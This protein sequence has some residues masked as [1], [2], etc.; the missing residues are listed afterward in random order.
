M[1]HVIL[2]N[3]SSYCVND[4]HLEPPLGLLYIASVLM[5]QSIPVQVYDMTGCKTKEDIIKKIEQIPFGDIY[6]FT[7]YCTNYLYVK[8]CIKHIRT[9]Y[10][11]AF[12]ILGGPNPSALPKF[13]LT[14]SQCDC[15]IT[16]EG[17]D[18]FLNIV[19]NFSHP[20]Y[21]SK[22]IQ[23]VGRQ[24]I[25]SYPFPARDLVNL[26]SY[27]RRSEDKR[28]I[29]LIGSRG[30]KYN[31]THCNSVVMGGGGKI[32]YR[33]SNNVIE[34]LASLQMKGYSDFRFNDDNFSGNPQ[35]ETLLI[36]MKRLDIRYRIF[37]RIE[38]LNEQ[39]C[40]LLAE[41]GCCHIS[42]GL[43]SLNPDN[44]QVLGKLSQQGLI[45]QN[46]SYTEKYGIIV[47]AYFM[48]GLPYDN[49]G[50]ISCY[51]EKAAKL[52]FDEFSLYPLIP[53]PG[54]RIA[55]FP[56]KFGYTVIDKDFTNYIQIGKNKGTTFALRHKNFTEHDVQRWLRYVENL[57]I[58]SRKRL[59][60][61]SKI[62]Q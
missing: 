51:F 47:R 18:A 14:D 20:S 35:I 3:P 45:E 54:T 29:S 28:V 53:Y 17:E 26:H 12:I 38:D 49:D 37:A 40:R 58:S 59:Q 62:A 48:V 43:E 61:E 1:K 2:I 41:S 15:V 27:T 21:V 57:F 7:T 31:C 25:D 60:C 19:K 5:E 50:T 55:E 46:L 32:R 11:N 10:P 13:T 33:S 56:E 22:I 44:L 39:N 24:N 6:G 23:G 52:P 36:K 9:Q 30:C 16:G 4:D 8:Q 42:V 34:E